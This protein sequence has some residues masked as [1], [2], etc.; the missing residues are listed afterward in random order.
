MK[1]KNY[2]LEKLSTF[3]NGISGPTL[4]QSVEDI[5]QHEDR[6]ITFA[7]YKMKLQN[8]RSGVILWILYI[9][10]SP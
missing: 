1:A 3:T 5:Y 2:N 9:H 8:R 7:E 6:L 10:I 4:Q